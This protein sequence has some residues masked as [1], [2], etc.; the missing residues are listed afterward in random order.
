[1]FGPLVGLLVCGG[2]FHVNLKKMELPLVLLF[3]LVL[4]VCVLLLRKQV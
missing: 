1:M 4:S 2:P 3:S